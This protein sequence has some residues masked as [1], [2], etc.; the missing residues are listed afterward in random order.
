MLNKEK[1]N[2]AECEGMEARLLAADDIKR[3]QV[4]MMVNFAEYCEKHSLTY[5]LCGGTLLGAVRH[6]G[7]IPWDDD[8]DLMMP[9]PDYERLINLVSGGEVISET[10]D[11][12]DYHFNDSVYPF[13]KL[14]DCRTHVAE[15]FCRGKTGI[16][17]DIFPIDGNFRDPVMNWLHYKKVRVLRK[18]VECQYYEIG[19]EKRR[20]TRVLR[21]IIS[22]ILRFIPH[23]RLCVYLNRLAGIKDYAS[24]ELVGRVLMG[25]GTRQRTERWK[26][27]KLV[28]LEFEG[29]YFNAP[30]NY[31]ELLTQIYGDYMTLPPAE[32]R[33]NHGIRAYWKES[34]KTGDNL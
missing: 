12:L 15:E 22:P 31:D 2:I 5:M 29:H 6:K 16:W 24:S 13:V 9:R 19:I 27:S 14:S 25:Y 34:M 32:Q 1:A 10:I 33:I 23:K 17:I 8:V 11:V 30:S 28:K 7:F 21:I 3:M 26:I 18:L 20:A 4:E